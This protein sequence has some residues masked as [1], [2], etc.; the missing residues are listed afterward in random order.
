MDS[1]SFVLCDTHFYAKLC[2]NAVPDCASAGASRARRRRRSRPRALV[3]QAAREGQRVHTAS[4]YIPN[5]PARSE[6]SESAVVEHG[7][8]MST[9]GARLSSSSRSLD[10]T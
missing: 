1:F 9:G 5:K 6:E 3:A 10:S 4:L 2:C 7:P 8:A